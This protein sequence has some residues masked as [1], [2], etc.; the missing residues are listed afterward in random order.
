MLLQ[1]RMSIP[2][3]FWELL[4]TEKLNAKEN[5]KYYVYDCYEEV[6]QGN[7]SD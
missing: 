1:L 4:A 3:A 5:A 7:A 2:F 6:E